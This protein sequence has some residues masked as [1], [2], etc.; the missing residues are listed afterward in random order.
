VDEW[1]WVVVGDLPSAYLVIDVS[2]TPSQ[3]LESYIDE[4]SK[5]VKLAKL[6]RSSKKVIPVNVPATPESAV[7]LEGRLKF[8]REVMVPQFQTAEVERA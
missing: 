5:W 6:G 2:K 4:I 8:L 1:L 3:A 7:A